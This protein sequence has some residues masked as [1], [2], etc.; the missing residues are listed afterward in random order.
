MKQPTIYDVAEKACVSIST[1]SLALNRPSKVSAATL[2]RIMAVVDELGFSLNEQA[3]NRTRKGVGRIGVIAPFT[4]YPSFG[5]RLNGVL[6]QVA[7]EPREIVV[8]NE[9]SATKAAD[10]LATLPVWRGL[11]GLIIMS[12]PFGADVAHRLKAQ[13]LPTVLVDILYEGFTSVV[14]D[15][16]QGGEL[17]ARLFLESGHTSFAY[18]GERQVAD[19]YTSA[20]RSRLEGFTAALEAKGQALD[21]FRVRIVSH[22]LAEAREAALDL[23]SLPN[24]PTAIFCYADLPAAG[25]LAAAQEKGLDVPRDLAVIG[26]DDSDLAAA[27]GLTSLNQSLKSSGAMAMRELDRLL[28]DPSSTPTSARIVLELGVTRRRSA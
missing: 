10:L 25:V 24:P 26:C 6:E 15:D 4:S 1:V 21:P 9:A 17:A 23:L 28:A 18:L 12:I 27:L 19:Y 20:S 11:D 13:R 7:G 14:A 3:A 8:F 2:A 16:R 22:D 5:E